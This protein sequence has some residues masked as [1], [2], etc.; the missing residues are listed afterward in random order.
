MLSVT[1]HDYEKYW[2]NW[3]LVCLNQK[4]LEGTIKSTCLSLY[5]RKAF[6]SPCPGTSRDNRGHLLGEQQT[7]H[8]TILLSYSDKQD[9][10][11][12]GPVS[13]FSYFILNYSDA[14]ESLFAFCVE[15]T[16][17]APQDS[18]IPTFLIAFHYRLYPERIISELWSKCPY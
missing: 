12:S 5:L 15:K 17:E 2:S 18:C 6:L 16:G 14:K 7:N 8:W 1:A 10:F 13:V 4:S 11:W 9:Q 3:L